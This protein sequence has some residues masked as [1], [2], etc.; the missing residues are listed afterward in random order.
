MESPDYRRGDIRWM[1]RH[2]YSRNA[3]DLDRNYNLIEGNGA[4][5]ALRLD[6]PGEGLSSDP[7]VMRLMQEM[8]FDSVMRYGSHPTLY[9]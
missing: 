2:E 1:P 3:L 7:A 8:H 9:P 6:Y 4:F 5:V